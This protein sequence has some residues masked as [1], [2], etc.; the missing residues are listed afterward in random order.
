MRPLCAGAE[1]NLL[2]TLPDPWH[3]EV[4]FAHEAAHTI[5]EYASRDLQGGAAREAELTA[6]RT[7]ALAGGFWQSTYAASSDA[8]YWAEGV[9][10]WLG[11]NLEAD[12]PD[13]IHNHVNTRAELLAYDPALAAFVAGILD[14][15]PWPLRCSLAPD[16]EPASWP[17]LPDPAQ[18]SCTYERVWL[19]DLG[20]DAPLHGDAGGDTVFELVQRGTTAL[21]ADEFGPDG[22]LLQS[23]TLAPRSQVVRS[24]QAGRRWRLRTPEGACLAV[25][26]AADGAERSRYA[27]EPPPD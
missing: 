10:S 25:L 8:E 2:Q 18:A 14:P 3:G 12:P 6:L 20:C 7:A 1:E 15:T 4:V 26:Q 21:V 22:T 9:Q 27:Y 5:F 19:H 17:I 16:A 11:D 24:T 23:V 13:G